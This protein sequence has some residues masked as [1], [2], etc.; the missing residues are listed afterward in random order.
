MRNRV[1][2]IRINLSNLSRFDHFHPYL[3]L[4]THPINR[5][6]DIPYLILDISIDLIGQ[7]LL[8]LKVAHDLQ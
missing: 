1:E 6:G 3:I 7:A 4:R 2:R 5:L 8:L